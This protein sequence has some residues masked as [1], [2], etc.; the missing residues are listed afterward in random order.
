MKRWRAVSNQPNKPVLREPRAELRC[1]Q[2]SKRGQA[3]PARFRPVPAR[4]C[5]LASPPQLQ[6]S[7]GNDALL[8]AH[9]RSH[10]RVRGVRPVRRGA[11]SAWPQRETTTR[12]SGI[13]HRAVSMSTHFHSFF[14]R[15]I[16]PLFH[17]RCRGT[18]AGCRHTTPHRRRGAGRMPD[19]DGLDRTRTGSRGNQG[20]KKRPWASRRPA[21][22]E[23][24][25]RWPG[26]RRF[27]PPKGCV[28]VVPV[29]HAHPRRITHCLPQKICA[30]CRP[31]SPSLPC[32]LLLL[33]DHVPRGP[34]RFV[35]RPRDCLPRPTGEFN[36]SSNLPLPRNGH[37]PWPTTSRIFFF[38][39]ATGA[40]GILLS[41]GSSVAAVLR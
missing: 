41:H 27:G 25:C 34:P 17:G 4:P 24:R 11:S 28:S 22:E 32:R 5:Q 14:S 7:N 18:A 26:R 13:G 12:S 15:D 39:S 23:G 9:G 36:A 29:S 30:L 19:G 6:G 37:P 16:P 40:S 31:H 35:P 1:A 33:L 8:V 3:A 2:G 20:G 38:Y 10:A 21:H